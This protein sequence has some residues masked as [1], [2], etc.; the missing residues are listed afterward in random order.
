MGSQS[1]GLTTLSIGTLTQSAEL[2]V[3]RASAESQR[4]GTAVRTVVR[5]VDEASLAQE[6]LHLFR[7]QS[8]SRLQ[9]SAVPCI[10]IDFRVIKDR[11]SPTS[12][13]A[14]FFSLEI[15][16]VCFQIPRVDFYRRM[17][18]WLSIAT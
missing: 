3:Q 2:L 5:V 4:S 15:A 13:V 11:R 14:P 18:Q 12:M 10:S 1:Q 8:V 16:R 9:Q 7:S 17:P 6:F